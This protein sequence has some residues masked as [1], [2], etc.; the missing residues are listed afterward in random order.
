MR[1][2]GAILALAAATVACAAV[3]A[4]AEAAATR[5]EYLAQI[6]PICQQ[7]N[8]EAKRIARRTNRALK[9]RLRKANQQAK[10]DD[11]GKPVGDIFT[12]I[13]I[14]QAAPENRLF[15][16]TTAM[17][18]GVAPA[19]GDEATVTAWLAGRDESTRLVREAIKAGKNS[20]PNQM[21]TLL[22]E[23]TVALRKG[24]QP[25]QAF[26]LN[27]CFVELPVI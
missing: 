3:P 27:H 20:K 18:R 1:R 16:R 25:V 14:K 9:K 8:Q 13:I 10:N 6:E 17:I 23:S 5:A 11:R 2:L 22:D 26:G 4:S 19:P 21:F 7:A 24:Q 15:E 12:L